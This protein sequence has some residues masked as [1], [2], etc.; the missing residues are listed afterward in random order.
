MFGNNKLVGKTVDLV[1]HSR[2]VRFALVGGTGFFINEGSLAFAKIVLHM[3]NHAGWLFAFAV[4]VTYT[5]VGNRAI[6]FADKAA[7]GAA[8]M[9]IEWAKFV[10]TQSVGAGLNFIV[11]TLLLAFAPPPFAIP[12]VALAMG[13]LVGLVFNFV[14][15]ST[16]V[17]SRQRDAAGP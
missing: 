15:S 14:L 13:I 12:Y 17:F 2:F 8:A 16:L 1:H 11:Y 5:W 10:A 4:G 7:K 3:G 6:T 9:A